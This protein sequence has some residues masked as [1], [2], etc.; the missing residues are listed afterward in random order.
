MNC[1]LLD[2]K[3]AMSLWLSIVGLFID[4]LVSQ[5]AVI[6]FNGMFGWRERKMKERKLRNPMHEFHPTKHIINDV[7]FFFVLDEVVIH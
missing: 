7:F 4:G 1:F 2:H 3:N 6:V 5:I